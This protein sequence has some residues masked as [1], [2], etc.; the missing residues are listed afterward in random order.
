[1]I[2]QIKELNEIRLKLVDSFEY[3]VSFY[4]RDGQRAQD[5]IRIK[6]H[7]I[8]KLDDVLRRKN[9]RIREANNEARQGRLI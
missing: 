3:E 7:E 8:N 4:N 2:K 9:K 1:M 5:V 6:A